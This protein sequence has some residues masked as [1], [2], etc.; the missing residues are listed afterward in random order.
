MSCR[1]DAPSAPVSGIPSTGGTR[2]RPAGVGT[3]AGLRL[4]VAPASKGL[5]LRRSR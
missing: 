4:Q 3:V 2:G 5:S 1:C